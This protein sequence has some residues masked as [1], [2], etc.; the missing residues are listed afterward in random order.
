MGWD[1]PSAKIAVA[2]LL[3]LCTAL[4]FARA[5]RYGAVN[6]DDYTY[7][8]EHAEVSSGLTPK[9]VVWAF[10][11][12]EDGIYMPLTWL[13]YMLDHSLGRFLG[14]DGD[15]RR[16]RLENLMHLHGI[17]L[18][19][20]NAVLLWL[21]LCALLRRLKEDGGD[22]P[23]D[24]LAMCGTAVLTLL[25]SLHPLRCESVV[26]IASRKDL[27][28]FGWLMLALI[29]WV[30]EGSDGDRLSVSQA[31]AVL[32]YLA[33]ALAKPSVMTFPLLVLVI[34]TFILRSTIRKGRFHYDKYLFPLF[35]MCSIAALASWAQAQGGAT[36]ELAAVPIWWKAL[37]AV[38]AMGVY[39]MHEVVPT[40]LAA[41]CMNQWPDLPRH[42]G[43]GVV[44]CAALGGWTVFRVL[45]EWRAGENGRPAFGLGGV[46]FFLIAVGPMLGISGFG[47]HAYADRFTY[48]PAVGLSMAL[49]SAACGKASVRRGL[50]ALG[51]VACVG[52]GW[53]A[54]RQTGY[55][56]DD[57]TL[58]TRTLEVD[59]VE[60]RAANMALAEHVFERDHDLERVCALLENAERKDVRKT[61]DTLFLHVVALS[62]LGRGDE[63]WKLLEVVREQNEAF[64]ARSGLDKAEYLIA[65]AAFC[66]TDPVFFGDAEEILMRRFGGCPK[67]VFRV[68]LL[69]RLAEKRGN[70]AERDRYFAQIR[71][72]D[73]VNN[74][75]YRM[76][77]LQNG[78]RGR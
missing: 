28:S 74:E 17:V 42:V 40:G 77:F 29:L 73:V 22:V 43:Q 27:I 25:W 31:F 14:T 72:G 61:G 20:V 76:S 51:A 59:G 69:G 12:V 18:H 5:V 78:E 39:L 57:R 66:L 47:Y 24:S 1:K 58:W 75:F 6:C 49:L 9:G 34:D 44:L 56:R 41:Q 13:S 2:A 60:S 7:A 30:R 46:L 55:W 19:S 33:G 62:E 26:W 23:S 45:A 16:V 71:S 21:F 70:L 3:F 32:C 4:P 67:H 37:N 11:T 8:Y 52:Y 53:G 10:R 54:F 38:A 50:V 65:R 15:S 36:G 68:Y 64:K 48:I 35:L 63:A